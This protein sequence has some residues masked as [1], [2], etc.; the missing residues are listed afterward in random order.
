[1]TKKRGLGE[2]GL[3]TFEGLLRFRGP[4]NGPLI[5]FARVV[6]VSLL[7]LNLAVIKFI[8]PVFSKKNYYKAKFD[9]IS[10]FINE[11]DWNEEL[12]SDDLMINSDGLFFKITLYY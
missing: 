3:G 4:N 7:S 6:R 2:I 8:E 9:E 11:I 1:M 5:V 10:N 12:N